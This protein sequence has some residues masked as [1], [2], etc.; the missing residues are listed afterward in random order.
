MLAFLWFHD[1]V[2]IFYVTVETKTRSKI[3]IHV[4][5][6]EKLSYRSNFWKTLFLLVYQYINK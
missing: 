5:D 6:E 4:S 1:K 2:V 3:S